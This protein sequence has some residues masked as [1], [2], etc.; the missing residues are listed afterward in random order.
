[1]IRVASTFKTSGVAGAI[2][3]SIRENGEAQIQGIGAG[4][5]NQMMKATIRAKHF[6]SEEGTDIVFTPDY[7]E[8]SIDGE[9]RTALRLTVTPTADTWGPAAN[10]VAVG[11]MNPI[12]ADY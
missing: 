2:A 1:M 3:H 4:A 7:V 12:P 5:V 6:L 10:N 11:G 8:V 9:M